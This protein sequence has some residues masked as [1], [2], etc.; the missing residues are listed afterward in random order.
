MERYAII[1]EKF[2]REFVLLQGTGCRWSKCSFCDYHTDVSENPYVVNKKVLSQ[3][4]GQY[5][6]L[7]V[8]N[9]GSGIELDK[10]TIALINQVVKEKKIHTLW[11]EMH[12]MYRNHLERFAQQFAPT[13]VKFRCGIETF[14]ADLRNKWNKGVSS[15][16]TAEDIARYFQGVCLLCGTVGELRNRILNDI[17]LAKQ[18]F[19]KMPHVDQFP[20]HTLWHDYKFQPFNQQLFDELTADAFFPTGPSAPTPSLARISI[21]A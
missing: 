17:Q 15:E 14:D 9:S 18:Y 8:I 5:G 6:V 10:D 2:P 3:V 16:V 19:D 21:R 7:D 1:H 4:T 13:K 20:T 11:F 12:Y